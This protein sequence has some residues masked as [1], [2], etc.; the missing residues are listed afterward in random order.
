MLIV[1]TYKWHHVIYDNLVM[2]MVNTY[3]LHHVVQHL[4]KHMG[5]LEVE[6]SPGRAILIPNCL[7]SFCSAH[8]N[9]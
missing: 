5:L 7:N 8:A 1:N 2:L 9:F 4:I 6:L 3:I